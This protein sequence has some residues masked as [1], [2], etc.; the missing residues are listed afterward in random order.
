MNSLVILCS[1]DMSRFMVEQLKKLQWWITQQIC[2]A[3]MSD[4][5]RPSGPI[6]DNDHIFGKWMEH[7]FRRYFDI[8]V[9]RTPLGQPWCNGIGERFHRSLKLE[10]LNRV[11]SLDVTGI[12]RL[13]VCYQEYMGSPRLHAVSSGI[14]TKNALLHFK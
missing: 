9:R 2:N 5:K 8:V 3:E 1:S 10:L 6:A 11:G 13:P 7:D 4:Y 12:R 14:V